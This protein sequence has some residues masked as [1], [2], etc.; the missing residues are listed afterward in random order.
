MESGVAG[1]GWLWF[2][3]GSSVG[4]SEWTC[5]GIERDKMSRCTCE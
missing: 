3:G 5:E 4:D 2:G 1:C